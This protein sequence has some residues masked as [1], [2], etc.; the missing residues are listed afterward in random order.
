MCLFGARIK[1]INKGNGFRWVEGMEKY[2]NQN[3]GPSYLWFLLEKA[4]PPAVGLLDTL[5]GILLGENQA[6]PCLVPDQRR[7]IRSGGGG[8]GGGGHH[9]S[10]PTLPNPCSPRQNALSAIVKLCAFWLHMG[11]SNPQGW[12]WASVGGNGS[13]LVLEVSY[14]TFMTS[15]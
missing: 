9:L 4:P 15:A 5:L 14:G 8:H 10:H 2:Y 7:G 6:D 3:R 11:A 13:P 1:K 12:C